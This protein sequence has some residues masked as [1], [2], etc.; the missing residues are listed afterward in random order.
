MFVIVN[1]LGNINLTDFELYILRCISNLK[2]EHYYFMLSSSKSGE[3]NLGIARLNLNELK[4]IH[5]I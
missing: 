5:D 2:F 4:S 3:I 1:L